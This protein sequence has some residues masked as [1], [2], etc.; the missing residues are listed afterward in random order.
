MYPYR[1]ANDCLPFISLSPYSRPSY[2]LQ[3]CWFLLLIPSHILKKVQILY[4]HKVCFDTIYW[5]GVCAWVHRILFTGTWKMFGLFSLVHLYKGEKARFLGCKTCTITENSFVSIE[6]QFTIFCV[7][8][9]YSST[10]SL[11]HGALNPIVCS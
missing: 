3:C 10:Y 6:Q 9:F 8:P 4:P 7:I 11:T 5:N 1:F 2:P